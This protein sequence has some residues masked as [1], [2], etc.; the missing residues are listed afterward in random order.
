MGVLHFDA[1]LD[2]Y[3]QFGDDLYSRCSPF[4]RLYIDENMDPSKMVHIGIRGPRNHQ[5]EYNNAQKFGATIIRAI[6]VKEMD[7]KNQFKRR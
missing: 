1:H 7:G 3:S 2:N 4:Y 5:E 6:D